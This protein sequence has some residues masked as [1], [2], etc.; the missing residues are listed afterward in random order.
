MSDDSSGKAS[1]SG[2]DSSASKNS[3][4]LN[5]AHRA[6][7]LG[8]IALASFVDF[9]PP[10]I[11]LPG[12]AGYFWAGVAAVV[13]IG[14]NYREFVERASR[15]PGLTL[16]MF[17]FVGS[18]IV[19]AAFS[20][21]FYLAISDAARASLIMATLLFAL[22]LDEYSRRILA[23][24]GILVL[25]A[26]V[27]C[28]IFSALGVMG[29]F[30]QIP[31]HSLVDGWPRLRAW[32]AHPMACGMTGL[33]AL[34]LSQLSVS[35]KER[36]IGYMLGIPVVLATLSFATLVL[37]IFLLPVMV[38]R[39]IRAPLAAVVASFALTM[40]WFHPLTIEF[41]GTPLISREAPEMWSK[42]DRGAEHMPIVNPTI[43]S[44]VVTGFGTGYWYLSK[45]S[46]NCFARNLLR[47]TGTG[48]IP[49]DCPVLVM[50]THGGWSSYSQGHNAWTSA[51]AEHGFVGVAGSL[52]L[53]LALFANTRWR[54]GPRE[55]WALFAFGL[56][57][58]GGASPLAIPVA[59]IV[60][61]ALEPLQRP[62]PAGARDG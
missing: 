51:I 26:L 1:S 47:G 24:V 32:L 23:R 13:I 38:P 41:R 46:L 52:A 58:F 15:L 30:E 40:L 4:T 37:P 34:A 54:G 56:L 28:W 55:F 42:L 33:H 20:G 57:G 18:R 16:A 31:G 53:I 6:W 3:R 48:L 5:T 29:G 9:A 8:M 21:D 39:L 60:A 44:F 19:S 12:R 43:G 50:G 2:L 61:N 27:C 7:A 49:R 45:N 62:I 10:W 36:I 59:L 17:L 11:S 22:G 14:L 25:I 35:S